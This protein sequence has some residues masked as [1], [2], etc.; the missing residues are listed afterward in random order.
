MYRCHEHYSEASCQLLDEPRCPSLYRL[1]VVRS[2]TY[3]HMHCYVLHVRSVRC[4]MGYSKLRSDANDDARD[5]N[6]L[7]LVA[8]FRCRSSSSSFCGSRRGVCPGVGIPRVFVRHK[9]KRTPTI[10][11]EGNVSAST[12]V[13]VDVCKNHN[14]QI[15]HGIVDTN[16]RTYELLC[17]VRVFKF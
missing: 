8:S 7:P 15:S 5:D 17:L 11:A 16:A 3:A 2:Y 10:M 6:A 4:H 13:T 14:V 1:H 9:Q 12:S